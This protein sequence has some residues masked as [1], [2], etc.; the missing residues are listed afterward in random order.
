MRTKV[1]IVDDEKSMC[2]LIAGGL[3]RAGFEPM[4]ETSAVAALERMHEHDF[5]VV[6]TDLNMAKLGGLDLCRQV[7]E[8]RPGLPV[9]VITAFGSMD[10][11]I[12]AIRAGAYDFINKPVDIAVLVLA[13]ER[14]ARA[15]DLQT[16]VT[17]LR[18]AV[19]L[20]TNFGEL[21]GTSP[22]MN[23]LYE[24]LARIADSDASVLIQGETGTGKELVAR[25]IHKRS[26]RSNG[27]FVA[28]NCAAL[29]AQLLESEFF[30]HVRGAFTDAKNAHAGI[31][32]QA[33]GGT[34]FLDEIGELPVDLQPKLLRAL[35]E[36]KVRPVGGSSELSFDVRLI[37]AT[38]RDLETH[39]DDGTF[40]EDLLYRIN[41]IQ[42]DVPPL[43]VRGNDILVLAQRFIRTFAKRAGRTIEGLA[44]SAAERL[45]GYGWPGNVRELENCMERAVALAQHDHIVVEDLPDRI[46]SHR[47]SKIVVSADDS[48]DFVTVHE[49]ERRYI[50]RVLAA[51]GGNKRQAAM[52]L[53]LDRKTLWRKLKQYGVETSSS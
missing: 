43:R 28:V 52:T 10:T 18:E 40:R 12:A 45:L 34:V 32:E 35:Q 26:G 11:A 6:L 22:A 3:S 30:G 2:E 49:L 47:A 33:N 9:I 50:L 31:F 53:G 1:L 42:A 37:C 44:T 24:L 25:A 5:Q 14:A 36:R 21:V 19:D 51:Y 48:S 4:W 20:N 41:V 46:R 29:P 13:V 7:L 39:V 17:R 27:K 38:N 8:L 15:Y 23:K 16:E